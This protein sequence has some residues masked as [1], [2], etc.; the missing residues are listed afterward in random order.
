MRQ[1]FEPKIWGNHAWFFLETV[2]MAYPTNP[3]KSMK[4]S[5]KKF[6]LALKDLIPCEKCRNNYALHLKEYPLTEKTLSSRDNLFV[7]I[8][9][10]H[11]CVDPK[12]THSYDETFKYYLEKY[13][14]KNVVIKKK[15]KKN[16][17][18]LILFCLLFLLIYQMIFQI[19]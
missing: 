6:F 13:N 10:I 8:V 5:A 12:N 16:L 7:W 11:N 1:N 2:C 4:S 9:N 18:Y 14:Y 3:S 15:S 19:L 17:I